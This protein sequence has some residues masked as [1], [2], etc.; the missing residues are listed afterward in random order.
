[1]PS[2]SKIGKLTRQRFNVSAVFLKS[3][4]NFSFIRHGFDWEARHESA[5]HAL[6]AD[7]TTKFL[8]VATAIVFFLVSVMFSYGKIA[9][10]EW[11]SSN[12][13]HIDIYSIAFSMTLVAFVPAV[14]LSATIGVPQSVLSA[15]RILSEKSLAPNLPPLEDYKVRAGLGHG[16]V[17]SWRYDRWLWVSESKSLA[18][19][20][21]VQHWLWRG[22]TAV[23]MV[24]MGSMG[25]TILSNLIP[26]SGCA[27]CRIKAELVIWTSYILSYVLG[28]LF[29]RLFKNRQTLHF[30]IAMVKDVTVVFI[31]TAV[32]V[33][34]V[35]GSLNK[36]ECW[37]SCDQAFME[38][39][40]NTLQSVLARMKREYPLII[41][42]TFGLSLV[43]SAIVAIL[44]RDGMFIYL[45][46][47]DKE[48][49]ASDI[50]GL[51][52]ASTVIASLG[53]TRSVS[54]PQN[55]PLPG[56]R[57]HDIRDRENRPKR[58]ALGAGNRRAM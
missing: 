26:P 16:A 34:T 1:M 17:P 55:A 39:P 43:I 4:S 52:K 28:I 48:S 18:R 29:S 51:R 6:A 50:P 7:R 41:S 13:W 45:Q 15:A 24:S 27:N 9:T 11:S 46:R 32:I 23:L 54:M 53:M 37:V 57:A 22:L 20:E 30:W 44:L 40:G 36:P 8:P 2:L 14:L 35:V 33:L 47:D 56:R 12:P 19:T 49:R 21:A 42:L 58:G 25:A 31:V 10:S 5:A 38:L 3:N